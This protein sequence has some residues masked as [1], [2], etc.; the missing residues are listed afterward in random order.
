MVNSIMVHTRFFDEYIHFELMYT[1]HQIFP[2]LT[3]KHLVN[4]DGEPTTPHKLATDT[5]TLVSNI[6]V[7]FFP[8]VVKKET[9]HINR[10]ALNIH[11]QLKM[12]FGVYLLEL[13]NTKKGAWYTYL[14][15]KI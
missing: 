1:T 4:Q 5:K 3:I 6:C 13:H 14:V 10:K 12:F 2:V 11:H 8:Y 15:H 7:P 9:S